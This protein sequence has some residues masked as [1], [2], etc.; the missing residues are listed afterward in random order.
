MKRLAVGLILVAL[1]ITP[2]HA[3]YWLTGQAVN[4]ATNQVLVTTGSLSEQTAQFVVFLRSTVAVTLAV[5]RLTS[6][7]VAVANDSVQFTLAA[8]TSPFAIPLG[9][10]FN[11][12]DTFQIR[13]VTGV[14]GAVQ[15]AIRFN[16][17]ETP[18]YCLQGL[19]CA[20]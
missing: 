3:G 16:D 14:T 4:P 13:V 11:A 15:A 18:G 7:S 20:H 1:L 5:E 9:V 6:G 17:G 19:G 2:A 10:A 12:G 8:G